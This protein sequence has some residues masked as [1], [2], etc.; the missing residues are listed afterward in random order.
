MTKKKKFLIIRSNEDSI[1]GSCRVISP[2]LQAVYGL[3]E[4]EVEI[5]WFN[6]PLNYIPRG[7]I[8]EKQTIV[9][10]IKKIKENKYDRIISID[11]LPIQPSIFFNLFQALPLVY[12]PPIIFHVYGDFTYFAYEWKKFAEKF[13]KHPVRF[14]VA[15]ES[16]RRLLNSFGIS[17]NDIRVLF[18]PVNQN[19]FSYSSALRN[20]MR[21]KMGVDD[22][23]F[24]VTYAGR[25]S[26]QKN[27]DMLIKMLN[28]EAANIKKKIVLWIAGSFD[29][30]GAHFAG[31]HTHEGYLY[32]KVSQAVNASKNIEIKFLGHQKKAEIRRLMC[33][34]DAYM[35]FSLYHDEDFGMSPAE[36][37]ACGTPSLLTDWGGYSSFVSKENAWCCDLLEVD[38]NEYG[39]SLS[40]QSLRNFLNQQIEANPSDQ[41]RQK[42]S[43]AFL[44]TFSIEAC[45]E[46]IRECLF[47]EV[48]V[49]SGFSWK[50]SAL[51][52]VYGR[53]GPRK[54][55]SLEMIPS[56]DNLYYDVYKYYIS[57]NEVN[58]HE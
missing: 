49:F 44:K 40:R 37:L 42:N 12:I 32:T 34:A 43:E 19:D 21:Q 38:L 30:Q 2:N 55:V 46:R 41:E 7:V 5:D 3:L 11:H 28:H 25:V 4:D 57:K 33:A 58:K 8:E 17:E 51:N 9:D 45:L 18:F 47:D 27:V 22:E 48:K 15:S 56:I 1:W 54:E 23:T 13:A 24:V 20:E 50:L 16:Q 6:I 36:A 26:L 14:I 29:D 35:S 31:I 53:G 39:H 10:L 52:R